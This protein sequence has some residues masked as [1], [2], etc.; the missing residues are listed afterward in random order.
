VWCPKREGKGFP[1]RGKGGLVTALLL[2][3]HEP[4]PASVKLADILAGLKGKWEKAPP[5]GETDVV[6][7]G[8]DRGQVNEVVSLDRVR[9]LKT[10][11][12]INDMVLQL[13][14]RLGEHFELIRSVSFAQVAG[15]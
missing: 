1:V 13:R 12:D 4:L 9:G 5:P 8:F 3:R 11:V 10:A 14:D 15:P 2:V 7:R 6:V